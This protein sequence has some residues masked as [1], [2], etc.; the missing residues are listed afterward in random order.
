MV[1]VESLWAMSDDSP[2]AGI[3]LE[4]IWI[5]R[6]VARSRLLVAL[7]RIHI[8]DFSIARALRKCAEFRRRKFVSPFAEFCFDIPVPACLIKPWAPE[9]L[10]ASMI[11]S[12]AAWSTLESDVLFD[13]IV[14]NT[15]ILAD[16]S[17]RALQDDISNFE[18]G[19]PSIKISPEVGS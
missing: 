15:G 17:K 5:S 18:I 7:S 11:S 12:S 1:I 6:S 10:A 14:K 9:S 13:R 8:Q 4:R 19:S 3:Q 16:H 2:I